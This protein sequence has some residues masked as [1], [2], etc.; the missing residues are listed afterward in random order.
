MPSL[1]GFSHFYAYKTLPPFFYFT[2]FG[3]V[4][5]RL[6]TFFFFTWVSYHY[7]FI[8]IPPFISIIII[9][10][11]K[12]NIEIPTQSSHTHTLGFGAFVMGFVLGGKV[13]KRGGLGGG[14]GGRGKGVLIRMRGT[15]RVYIYIYRCVN[16]RLKLFNH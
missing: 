4:V 16:Q 9:I 10:S 12:R 13:G 8:Y 11:I 14:R 15:E 7:F 6:V 3:F 1:G 5:V 2:S